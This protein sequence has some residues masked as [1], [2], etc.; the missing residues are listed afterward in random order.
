MAE[1][2]SKALASLKKQQ[3]QK[4]AMQAAREKDNATNKDVML[5]W[6]RVEQEWLTLAASVD[7]PE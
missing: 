2:A 1:S 6:G 3:Y 5:F 7:D 4:L